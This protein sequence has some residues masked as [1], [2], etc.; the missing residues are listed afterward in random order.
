MNQEILSKSP[1]LKLLSQLNLRADAIKTAH[2]SALAT[3]SQLSKD[4]ETSGILAG[5]DDSD[6]SIVVFG[7]LARN[8]FTGRENSDVDWTLLVDGIA[9]TQDIDLVHDIRRLIDKDYKTPN[10]TGAFGNLSFSHDL[11]HQIGGADDTN[12]NTTQRLLLLLESSSLYG[13]AVRNRVIRNILSRYVFEDESFLNGKHKEHVPRFLL[14]DVTRY[15]R[16]MTVDFQT[17]RR[18]RNSKGFALRNIKLR[19]SRKLL[20]LAGL[21]TCFSFSL[22]ENDESVLNAWNTKT[23]KER[24]LQ[25]IA[26]LTQIADIPPLDL[27][28]KCFMHLKISEEAAVKDFLHA[29]N[30]FVALLS[31]K[32]KR[33]TLEKLQP[34]MMATDDIYNEARNES[35]KFQ[36]AIEK[37]FLQRDGGLLSQLTIK[38]G[39][40]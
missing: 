16:T 20:F 13:N 31:D 30:Y 4:I 11:I 2:E 15:W 37:I 6:R 34:E 7:S 5:G 33:E 21:I 3:K 10:A 39:V 18:E 8:E 38:Y 36:E 14:N 27:V 17:K 19:F 32:E 22:W 23:P 9:A 12:A 26:F 40:F 28:S 35:H 1:L 25:L 29:Y 24:G